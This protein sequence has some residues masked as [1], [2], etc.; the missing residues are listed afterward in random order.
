MGFI[1]TA[2]YAAER[3]DP[4]SAELLFLRF[5]CS[6]EP[7]KAVSFFEE[8]Q[9]FGGRSYVDAP[10]G[11][12]TGKVEICDFS[13]KWLS[14]FKADSADVTLVT[15]T[16]S[17]GRSASEVVVNFHRRAG[18]ISIPMCVVGDLRKPGKLDAVRIYFYYGWLPGFSAYRRIIFVP[19]Y[20]EAAPYSLMTGSV[21]KYFELLHE[22]GDVRK[23][24]DEIIAITTEDVSYGGY[25]PDWIEPADSG[26]DA[27]RGHY[28]G[29]C[30]DAPENYFVR[31]EAITDD[32]LQCVVEWTLIVTEKG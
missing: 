24:I 8:Q 32:G 17:G 16:V 23:R 4:T 1:S 5:L 9:Q 6:G 12:Y 7:K 14:D 21:R 3:I 29:I 11:R 2:P 28:E 19:E 27:L 15:Q 26:W 18:D 30:T 13:E 31:A 10:Q 20:L 22:S 25:R